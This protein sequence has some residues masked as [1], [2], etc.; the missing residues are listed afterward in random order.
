M[1]SAR[2]LV[3]PLFVSAFLIS[4]HLEAV[5]ATTSFIKDN[6]GVCVKGGSTLNGFEYSRDGVSN[7]SMYISTNGGASYTNI[8]SGLLM[9]DQTN[10]IG[11]WSHTFSNVDAPGFKLT[12]NIDSSRVKFKV[13]GSNDGQAETGLMSV[14]ATVP[15]TPA[16]SISNKTD[17]AVTLSW[18]SLSWTADANLVRDCF[19]GY[20]I[21]RDGVEIKSNTSL[22]SYTD[23]NL[24]AGKPYSYKVVGLVQAIENDPY[25]DND[26]KDYLSKDFSY[27]SNSVTATL[28][29]PITSV[30]NS[31]SPTPK[32]SAL[33][34][35]ATTKTSSQSSQQDTKNPVTTEESQQTSTPPEENDSTVI[36]TANVVNVEGEVLSSEKPVIDQDSKFTLKGKAKPNSKILVLVYSVPQQFEVTADG[37][38]TWELP[39]PGNLEAGDHRVEVAYIGNDGEQGQPVQVLSFYV[40]KK[41]TNL[42]IGLLLSLVTSVVVY[43][44]GRFFLSMI[45]KP[46]ESL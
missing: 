29:T 24:E 10:R 32:D 28:N 21:L 1:K 23:S 6:A 38:G 19:K 45:K 30:S 20:K 36:I 46:Q 11:Y 43:I 27:E 33:P 13:T 17:S 8:G 18:T 3:F 31:T 42:T 14:Y 44:L 7:Y 37:D 9:T 5:F 40:S 25:S 22:T 35:P 34:K 12:S 15:N 2:L 39:L 16:I 26:T 4:G 41:Q